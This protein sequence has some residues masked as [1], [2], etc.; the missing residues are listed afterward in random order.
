VLPLLPPQEL[1]LEITTSHLVR[2][3]SWHVTLL[4]LLSPLL[5]PQELPQRSQLPNWTVR[6]CS[7]LVRPKLMVLPLVL[8]Q[9]LP[10]EITTAAI[11]TRRDHTC[12]DTFQ[13]EVEDPLLQPADIKALVADALRLTGDK[14]RKADGTGT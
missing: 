10:L 3:A 13:V 11:T 1:P 2:C 6:H 7:P 5:L 4:L 9:E 12:V 8:P 14:K